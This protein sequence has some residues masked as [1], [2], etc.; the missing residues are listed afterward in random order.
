[1]PDLEGAPLNLG[2]AGVAAICPD[3]PN[4]PKNMQV[5][6][7]G[8]PRLHKVSASAC[9]TVGVQEQRGIR[10]CPLEMRVCFISFCITV[11]SGLASGRKCGTGIK[12][13]LK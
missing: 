11:V 12:A 10:M 3:S 5:I 4:G 8:Q 13:Y 9:S 6:Q 2:S 7:S 1:M